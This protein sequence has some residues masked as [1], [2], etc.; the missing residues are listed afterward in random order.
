[1]NLSDMRT[2]VRRD[3]R[4]EDSGN[5][6]WSDSELE[7]HIAHAVKDFSEAVPL[8]QKATVAT[9][10]GSREIDIS[11]LADIVMVEA[12]EY[13]VGKFPKRYQRFSLW[14]TT[15]VLLG[16]EVPD[17]GNACIYYG[18]LHTLSAGAST[19]PSKYEDLIACGA[20]GYAA[21]EWAAYAINQVNVGGTSSQSQFLIY[22]REKLTQFRGELRRLGRR[23]RI[24]V[25]QLY[26]PYYLPVA[27]TSDG[28]P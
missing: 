28:G 22:G 17:G 8:E 11:T 21:L 3:L 19:I 14:A 26:P 6:R 16:A 18:K 23:Q 5:Y 15:L 27:R 24:R 25:R 2:L 1:M 20:T 13:P 12:V 9:T 10:A 7:R 4:D